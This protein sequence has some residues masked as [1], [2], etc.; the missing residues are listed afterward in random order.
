MSEP[1]KETVQTS[2][3]PLDPS[4]PPADLRRDAPLKKEDKWERLVTTVSVAVLGLFGLATL[5]MGAG[6]LFIQLMASNWPE[7]LGTV[8][9]VEIERTSSSPSGGGGGASGSRGTSSWSSTS[10]YHLKVTYDYEVRGEHYT[11]ESVHT[12]G[13]DLPSAEARRDNFPMDEKA[14]IYYA[15]DDPALSTLTA[16][17]LTEPLVLLAVSTVC[18]TLFIILVGRARRR[19]RDAVRT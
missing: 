10:Y 11:L 4:D 17:E 18:T 12:Y 9:K 14:T 7:T 6:S 19:R 15:P 13:S 3:A 5:I 8:Q 1:T 16:G 2:G